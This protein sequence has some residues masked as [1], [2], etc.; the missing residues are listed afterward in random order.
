MACKVGS[1]KHQED[2]R[3]WDLR[4]S[5]AFHGKPM[6]IR[7][8]NCQIN[9]LN[10]HSLAAKRYDKGIGVENVLLFH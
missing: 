4:R 8:R 10:Q 6:N 1:N 3:N 2:R 7:H 9:R 5:E